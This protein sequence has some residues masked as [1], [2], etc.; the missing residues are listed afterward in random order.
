[1]HRQNYRAGVKKSP[2]F[3]DHLY[4]CGGAYFSLEKKTCLV[5]P[6]KYYQRIY[7]KKLKR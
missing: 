6:N 5:N 3:F 4:K 2:L 1:M 7:K